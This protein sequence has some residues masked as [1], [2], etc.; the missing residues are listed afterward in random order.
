M[1]LPLLFSSSCINTVLQ[2]F[3]PNK[4][5]ARLYI[6]SLISIYI[7]CIHYAP[8]SSSSEVIVLRYKFL[9]CRLC[10]NLWNFNFVCLSLI[11]LP[12]QKLILNDKISYQIDKLIHQLS[13]ILLQNDKERE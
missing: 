10:N 5:H 13:N 9:I 8:K 1:R 2:E 3:T 7:F 6:F 4:K 12:F 11:D